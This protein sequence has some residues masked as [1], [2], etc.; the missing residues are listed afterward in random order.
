MIG[1][2]PE[3]VTVIA[4]DTAYAGFSGWAMD[5]N[6]SGSAVL[7]AWLLAVGAFLWRGR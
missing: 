1:V 5:L 2:A 6:L 7:L 3:R 4:G